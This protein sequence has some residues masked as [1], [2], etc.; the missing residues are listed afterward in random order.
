MMARPARK[1]ESAA[2]VAN[3]AIQNRRQEKKPHFSEKNL[4]FKE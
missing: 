2:G 3:Y 1:K 4:F